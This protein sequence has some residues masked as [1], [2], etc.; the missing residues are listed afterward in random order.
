MFVVLLAF[1]QC[2]SLVNITDNEILQIEKKTIIAFLAGFWLA[3]T[4]TVIPSLN[5]FDILD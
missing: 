1:Q 3:F 4:S 5:P 2:M